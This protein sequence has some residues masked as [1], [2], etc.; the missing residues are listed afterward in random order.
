MVNAFQEGYYII[1]TVLFSEEEDGV[2]AEYDV[3][4]DGPYIT[5]SAARDNKEVDGGT[6]WVEYLTEENF[7]EATDVA[8]ANAEYYGDLR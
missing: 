5:E 8:R 1:G 6:T 3:I 4:I 7:Q 2:Y